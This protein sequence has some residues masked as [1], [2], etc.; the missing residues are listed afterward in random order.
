[1]DQSSTWTTRSHI[2]LN[3]VPYALL[4]RPNGS[5]FRVSLR[6]S[7]LQLLA[8]DRSHRMDRAFV[9]FLPNISQNNVTPSF[10]PCSSNCPIITS[11]TPIKG[12]FG[13]GHNIQGTLVQVTQYPR[14]FG[15]GRIGKLALKVTNTAL[16]NGTAVFFYFSCRTFCQ[17]MGKNGK[18]I[19]CLMQVTESSF[20]QT[21]Y[22]NEVL[23]RLDPVPVPY[24]Y[25]GSWSKSN[26]IDKKIVNL[27]FFLYLS[28]N[29][30]WPITYIK[31]IFHFKIQPFVTAKS[32]YEPNPHGTAFVWL[33]LR[34]SG[35][36]SALRQKAGSAL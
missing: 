2:G 25:C 19:H 16:K 35:S 1:M 27:N 4:T 3:F 6:C 15:W 24:W 11:V 29:I 5:E 21:K 20:I 9:D 13:Q 30:L 18:T 23:L 17:G 36:G 10:V 34:G 33:G 28:R 14:K 32:D 8:P 7:R 31:Y 26:E 22:C 12:W